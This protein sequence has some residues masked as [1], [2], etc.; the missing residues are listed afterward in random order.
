[1]KAQV[2]W[3]LAPRALA[4]LKID[5][6]RL[7]W[8]FSS[9][10]SSMAMPRLAAEAAAT[11]QGRSQN[12]GSSSQMKRS[13]WESKAMASRLSALAAA[14]AASCAAAWPTPLR[15]STSVSSATRAI[16]SRP[17]AAP[18]AA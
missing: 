4:P 3:R 17:A 1:M 13:R 9:S 16:P 7:T 12:S 2:T 6:Q 15:S 14:S 8:S 11:V 18:Y 10:F 5:A